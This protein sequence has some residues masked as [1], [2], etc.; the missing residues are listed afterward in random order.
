[1]HTKPTTDEVSTQESQACELA[2]F[3]AAT[4]DYLRLAGVKVTGRAVIETAR[5]VGKKFDD[6]E[7]MAIIRSWGTNVPS[8]PSKRGATAAAPQQNAVNEHKKCGATA[9]PPQKD[10]VRRA[11]ATRVERALNTKPRDHQDLMPE[12]SASSVTPVLA[13]S[14]REDSLRS[15]S[16]ELTLLE[17]KQVSRRNRK[18]PGMTVPPPPENVLGGEVLAALWARLQPQYRPRG[19]TL[20]A[21]RAANIRAAKDMLAAGLGLE[22]IVAGFERYER[23]HHGQQV[24][25]LVRLQREIAA[26][27]ADDQRRG[28]REVERYSAAEIEALP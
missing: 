26:Q 3:L 18:L 19:M 6:K 8:E 11:P 24:Y 25:S 21:W 1:M 23:E 28:V 12:A 20:T 10:A 15:S 9:E 27:H 13:S 16:G 4:R 5:R 7:A 14:S 22:Q 2:F 17:I